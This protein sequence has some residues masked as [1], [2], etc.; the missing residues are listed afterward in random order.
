MAAIDYLIMGHIA[1]DKTPQGPQL[2]GT[3]SYSAV[4]AQAMG[5]RVGMLTSAR[6]DDP[7]LAK[8]EGIEYHLVPSDSSTIFVNTYTDA[9][10]IQV[11]EGHAKVLSLSDL[12]AGWADAPVVHFGPIA[13]ELDDT[14]TPDCFPGALV[15]VTPQGYMRTWGDNGLVKPIPWAQAAAFLP[16]TVTVMSDEDL[17]FNEERELEYAAMAS[18]LVI[19]RGYDGA[20]LFVR[21][22]RVE[23]VPALEISK[24]R[25]L[26]GAG[27]VFCGAMLAYLQ[28]HPDAW[29]QALR[30][31]THVASVFVERCED[32]GVP[33]PRCMDMIMND[34]RV[35]EVL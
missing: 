14:L 2:G 28:G 33:G 12:P 34:P 5:L 29:A 32:I 10:R 30:V 35:R 1:H 19:T 21:G 23:D 11:V 25:H 8:L 13:Q 16:Q 24:P 17:G 4:T 18:H 22:E 3:V 26:T 6:P 15:A 27:D 7:V 20:S 9:G 31:G